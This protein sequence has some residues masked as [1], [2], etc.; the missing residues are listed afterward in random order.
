[1]ILSTRSRTELF[2]NHCAKTLA[3]S[4]HRAAAIAKA[5]KRATDRGWRY[6]E[7]DHYLQCPQCQLWEEGISNELFGGNDENLFGG[8]D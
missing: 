1:M 5:Y 3:I 6:F 7:E 4:K 8:P 2:C